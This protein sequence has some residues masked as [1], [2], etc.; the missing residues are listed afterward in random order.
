[1]VPPEGTVQLAFAMVDESTI[2]EGRPFVHWALAGV[3]PA[4]IS[5]LEGDVPTGAVQAEN[6]FG[7][8]G[9]S[10]PC[11]PEGDPEHSYRFTMYALNQQVELADGT[12]ADEFLDYI[13]M[14]TIASTDVTATYRR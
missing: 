8:I 3:D 11:P 14:V 13:Q 2:I 7:T 6:A 9:W 4:E 5:L 10:G 12:A 1:M